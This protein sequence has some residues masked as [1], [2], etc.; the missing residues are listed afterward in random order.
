MSG[1]EEIAKSADRSN[2]P[3]RLYI[4][5][6]VWAFITLSIFTP[7]LDGYETNRA[8]MRGQIAL[9]ACALL[10]LA[11]SLHRKEKSRGW[12]FYVT[13]LFLAAPLW[14]VLEQPLWSLGRTLWGRGLN[15]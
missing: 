4:G 15:R 12:V 8:R 10:R 9:L 5:A 11:W 13:L 6:L 3:I 14:L 2:W 7:S 1:T